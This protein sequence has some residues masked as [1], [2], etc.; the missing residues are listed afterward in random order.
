MA[1]QG[2][3]VKRRKIGRELQV[4]RETSGLTIEEAGAKIQRSD[5]TISRIE[6]G[7]RDVQLIELKGLLEAYDAPA[8]TREALLNLLSGAPEQAWWTN[9]DLPPKLETYVGLEAEAAALRVFALG[10]V[11]SLLRTEDYARAVLRGTSPSAPTGEIDSLLT[12]HMQRQQVLARESTPLDLVV[13]LDEGCLWRQV[14]GLD[15]QRDQLR[16][17]TWTTP[18][19]TCTSRRPRTPVASISPTAACAAWRSMKPSRRGS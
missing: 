1:I 2:P 16:W 4:L 6:N 9:F 13:V 11:H 7:Q 10:A 18:A 14:G 5:S 12:F 3:V 15:C 19:G 17:S 8:E